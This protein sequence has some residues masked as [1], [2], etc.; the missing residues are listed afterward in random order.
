MIRIRSENPFGKPPSEGYRE[1]ELGD[2]VLS[3]LNDL[4]FEI[5]SREI[6]P[7]RPNVWGRLKGRGSGPSLMLAGHLDTVGTEGYNEPFEPR[8]EH[9]RVYGRGACDMK[10]ALAAYLEVARVLVESGIELSGDL[11]IAGTADEEWRLAGSRDIGRNGPWADFGLIGEPTGL[12]ICPAHK[13]DYAV[14]IRTFGRAVHSSIPDEGHNAIEDM[15]RVINALA[16]YDRALLA[17]E[18]H[19]ICGHG[20]FSM[21]VIR[22][23]TMVCTI[24]DFCE[25]ELD[26]RTLPGETGES[27]KSEYRNFL[28]TRLGCSGEIRYEFS[29]PLTEVPPL[30]VPM[31]SPIVQATVQAFKS[32]TGGMATVEAYT[33]ATDAPNL[34][35]PAIIFGP[36]SCEQ[37][38]SLC[39]FV[40]IAELETATKVY[41]QTAINMVGSEDPARSALVGGDPEGP[42]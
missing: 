24:P 23:G 32:V 21:G 13:G 30:N 12:K 38:H 17:R 34:G 25:L 15:G 27:I 2:F 31:N 6:A 39:E 26:R 35:F 22:G 4:K 33:A 11:I 3:R 40:N 14:A 28:D 10:A 36:G 41:L 42:K 20:R 7:G 29:E 19:A 16:D 5:G 18:S 1:R 9:D 37:A 8:V